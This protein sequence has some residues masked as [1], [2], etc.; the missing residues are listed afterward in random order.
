[1]VLLITH[2]IGIFVLYRTIVFC[3]YRSIHYNSYYIAFFSGYCGNMYNPKAIKNK[4]RFYFHPHSFPFFFI[5][6]RTSTFHTVQQFIPIFF[7]WY[8][9][10]FGK[11]QLNR[12]KGEHVD[13]SIFGN[14]TNCSG[15][16]FILMQ[17][18]WM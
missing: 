6:L 13:Y 16:P 7:L 10:F 11:L 2:D 17:S 3:G 12:L 5:P 4:I 14:L 8:F 15:S 1:M 18:S 9:F